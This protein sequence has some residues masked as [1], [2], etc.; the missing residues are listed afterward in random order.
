MFEQLDPSA[1]LV[2]RR[3]N[4]GDLLCTTPM[5]SRLRTAFSEARID[6]LVNSYNAP[7]LLGNPDLDHVYYYTKAKHRAEG[8]TVIGVHLARLKLMLALRRARY[9]RIYLAG[10]GNIERQLKLARWLGARE[11]IGFR[12]AQGAVPRGLNCP[13]SRL[14]TGHEVERCWT[15]LGDA[16]AAERP[17]PMT[18]H[19]LPEQAQS[20]RARLA[21]LPAGISSDPLVAVHVS[22]RKVPQRWPAASFAALMRALHAEFGARFMLFWSP[23]D[24]DNPHHPGDDRKAAEIM[25]AVADLPVLPYPTVRLEELTGGL[26]ACSL[27]VCS[28]GGAMHMGAALG[29]PVVCFFGNSDAARWYPWAVPHRIVQKPSREV[30]EISVEEAYAACAEILKAGAS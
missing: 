14:E 11:I 9:D 4:I 15:L 6:A 2:I 18:L 3:D 30:A 22:A 7:V 1:I 16:F 25:A 19:P 8:Q 27:M 28:D 12:P 23:G 29:L 26:S 5:I 20:V 24:E 17:A 21:E 10:D 13:V